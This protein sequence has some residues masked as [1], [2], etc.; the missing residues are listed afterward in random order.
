MNTHF[1]K[2]KTNAQKEA[3]NYL[4]Q[5]VLDFSPKIDPLFTKS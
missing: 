4:E 1:P 2:L 5:Y 3:K